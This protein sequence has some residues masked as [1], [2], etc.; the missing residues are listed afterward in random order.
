MKQATVYTRTGCHLCEVAI[1]LLRRKG[2]MVTT[3]D[4]DQ[5]AELRA[6]YDQH[7]PVIVIDGK[8]R[9][10]GRVDETLLDRLIAAG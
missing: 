5:D 2:L 3:K 7:V 1:D 4:I 9:F 8:E 10:R 6:R